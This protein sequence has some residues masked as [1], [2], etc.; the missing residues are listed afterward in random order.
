MQVLI[1]S[2]LSLSRDICGVNVNVD[3]E[4]V[5]STVPGTM[6]SYSVTSDRVHDLIVSSTILSLA[7]QRGSF[8]GGECNFVLIHYG[9]FYEFLTPI[10]SRYVSVA[11]K[12][13]ADP[14]KLVKPILSELED[15]GAK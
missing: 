7:R 12:D 15:S 2:L 9:Q 6:E 5:S 11:I 13:D 4:L 1:D 14:I 10:S 3:G 8:E